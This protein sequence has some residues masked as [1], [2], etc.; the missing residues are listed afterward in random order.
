MFS[1]IA[2]IYVLADLFYT[3]FTKG[4]A[5]SFSHDFVVIYILL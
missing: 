5:F 4:R 3:S 1:P 2:L